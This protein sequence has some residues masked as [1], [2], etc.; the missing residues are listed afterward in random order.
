MIVYRYENAMRIGPYAGSGLFSN[1][2]SDWGRWPPPSED[3]ITPISFDHELHCGFT[4]IE[5]LKA[6]FDLKDRKILKDQGYKLVSLEVDEVN[7]G[8]H[9][10]VFKRKDAKIIEELEI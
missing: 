10:C 7:V 5:Q 1:H 3:G 6:W 2:N 9:Q 4:S 8:K